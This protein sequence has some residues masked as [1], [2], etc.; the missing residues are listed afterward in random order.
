MPYHGLLDPFVQQSN[1][2]I[3]TFSVWGRTPLA[4]RA[5]RRTSS[6]TVDLVDDQSG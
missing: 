4:S 2:G 1:I 6:I 3:S 5:Q